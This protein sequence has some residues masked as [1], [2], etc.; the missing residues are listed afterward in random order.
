MP[1]SELSPGKVTDGP[2]G[3]AAG[4]GWPEGG[5]LRSRSHRRWLLLL[6]VGGLGLRVLAAGYGG[7]ISRDGAFY[8]ELGARLSQGDLPGLFHPK[9]TPL[10]PFLIGLVHLVVPDRELSG[11]IVSVAVGTLTILAAYWLTRMLFGR[12]TG[13]VVAALTAFHPYLVRCSGE[14]MTEAAYTL[15]FPLALGAVWLA[16]GRQGWRWYALAGAAIGLSY[17]ARLEGMGLAL[18]LILG[19]VAAALASVRHAR[20]PGP[21]EARRRGAAGSPWL[22]GNRDDPTFSSTSSPASGSAPGSACGPTSSSTLSSPSG[23]I[24]GPLARDLAALGLAALVF[25]FVAF[26]QVYFVKQAMGVWSL[27]PKAGISARRYQMPEADFER[28]KRTLTPDKRELLIEALF[29]RRYRPALLAAEAAEPGES[30]GALARRWLR[31]FGQLVAFLPE[32]HGPLLLPFLIGLLYRRTRRRRWPAETYLL[33]A[34][35]FYLVALGFFQGSRRNLTAL[36]IPMLPFM[37]LGLE[38]LAGFAAR[39]RARSGGGKLALQVASRRGRSRWLG[40]VLLATALATAPMTLR[41]APRAHWRWYGS[42]EKDAGLW[43]RQ[44]LG[45]GRTILTLHRTIPFYAGAD[46]VGLPFAPYEDIVTYARVNRV[47][48]LL[49]QGS[50]QDRSPELADLLAHL[51]A[52]PRWKFLDSLSVEEGGR[53]YTYRL[54][55]FL[56][57]ASPPATQGEGDRP[58]T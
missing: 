6:V 39:W 25:L 21:V 45:P 28:Y 22:W 5:L 34:L 41:F 47:D 26:P 3:S 15:T 49:L 43:V 44:V 14:V 23:P 58:A 29:D 50:E 17:L 11:L 20:H 10:Y 7:A 51:P 4:P 24:C 53:S 2:Q 9:S 31:V 13:L 16:L 42:R 56:P 12:R 27:T 40:L 52:D 18:L 48:A 8:A 33:A 46:F 54:Y 55:R 30:P 37:A 1:A 32:V 38:E 19:T 35:L 36:T 57:E